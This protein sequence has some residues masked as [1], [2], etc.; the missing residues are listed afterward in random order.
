M[1]LQQVLAA[2]VPLTFVIY[3]LVDLSK[4]VTNKNWNGLVT[5]TLAVVAGFAVISLYAHSSLDVGGSLKYVSNV[6]WQGLLLAAL[7]IAASGGTLS[8]F[9]RTFNA[10]D[11]NVKDKLL[12]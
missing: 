8:D 1:N 2:L 5:K 7:I 11:A 12:K 10:S 3:W 6:P 9:L 4:D